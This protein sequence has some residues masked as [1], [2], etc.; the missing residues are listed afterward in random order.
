MTLRHANPA[1]VL[2]AACSRTTSRWRSDPPNFTHSSVALIEPSAV[3][4]GTLIGFVRR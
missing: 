3:T 4:V 2:A 1:I